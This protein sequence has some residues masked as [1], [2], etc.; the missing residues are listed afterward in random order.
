LAAYGVEKALAQQIATMIGLVLL[1]VGVLWATWRA[2]SAPERVAEHMLWLLLWFLFCCNLWF[3]PWYL[4]WLLALVALQPWR[5]RALVIV[6]VFCCT[7]M[8][9]C[10]VAWSFLRPTLGWDVES[11]RWNALLCV[12]I[13]GPL[14]VL[15]ARWRAG[16]WLRR[17]AERLAPQGGRRPAAQPD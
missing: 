17:W 3:Q 16:A 5:A 9:G 11:A 4:I 14:L 1:L 12:L 10:Y 6:G 13:Y 15:A 2:W 7:A 8:L